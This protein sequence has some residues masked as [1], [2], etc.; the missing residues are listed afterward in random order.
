MSGEV[1]RR[2]QADDGDGHRHY[3]HVDAAGRHAWSLVAA[4]LHE[5]Q[6]A[7]HREPDEAVEQPHD[8]QIQDIAA[9]L[10]DTFEREVGQQTRHYQV[11]DGRQE[12]PRRELERLVHREAR[13]AVTVGGRMS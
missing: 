13:M 12:E 11:H 9:V 1:Q 5:G 7:I 2:G 4:L 8:E 10:P 6:H 3:R